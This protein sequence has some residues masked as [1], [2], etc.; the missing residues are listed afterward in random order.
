[1]TIMTPRLI[2][3]ALLVS[4]SICGVYAQ[5]VV[6][7]WSIVD[8]GG[9]K[10]SAGTVTLQSSIGQTAVVASSD[11][12]V[13]LEDGYIPGLRRYSGTTY[14]FE[15]KTEFSWNMVS[16]PLIVDDFAKTVVYPIA[17]SSAFAYSGG[18]AAADTLENGV[19][20]WVKFGGPF[21]IGF[22]GTSISLDSID[23]AAGWNMIGCLTYPVIVDD[24]VAVAPESVLTSYFA[25]STFSGYFT[26]DTLKPGHG[27]WVKV[28]QA[29]K[30]VLAT[31]SVAIEPE[32]PP[33]ASQK[34]IK[35][36]R[37]SDGG[38]FSAEKWSSLTIT[39]ASGRERSVYYSTSAP[40]I[41]LESYEMPPLPPAGMD[42]RYSSNR[43]VETSI[44]TGVATRPIRITGA[45][46][47]VTLRW[48]TDEEAILL[49]EGKETVMTGTGSVQI[50]KP[51]AELSL[52]LSQS[53]VVELPKEFGL[54]QNYP[55][56]FNPATI[57]EY[58]LPTA[59]HV[60]LTVYNMLGQ[61][62]VNFFDEVQEAGFKSV[63]FDGRELPSGMYFYRITAGTFSDVKKML[64]LK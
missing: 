61:E 38:I 35:Q 42:V 23:V 51:V 2:L 1:M 28:K 12:G 14:S 32:A 45:S 13:N 16:V 24:I 60:K 39:D 44:K 46:Y 8:R 58:A 59:E 63:S 18:Y 25:Y 4:I 21:T 41:D 57:I 22:Q 17:T 31:G 5:T 62:V 36:G 56:P 52:R 48:E 47:P 64:L 27:Y 6:H 29:G 54:S 11:G 49:V 7:P 40:D 30:L 10:A 3:T 34:I 50:A 37:E 33:L 20:Y 15:T 53:T 55:N 19:G 43:N 9:G 26:E